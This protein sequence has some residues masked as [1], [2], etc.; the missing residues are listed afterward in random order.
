M[1]RYKKI[2]ENFLIEGELVEVKPFGSGH[3]NETLLVSINNNNLLEKYILRKINNH[4]FKDPEIV[5]L[6]TVYTINHIKNKMQELGESNYTHKKMNLLKTFNF[7]YYYKDLEGFYWCLFDFIDDAYTVDFVDNNEKAYQAAKA[8]GRFQKF[9][10]DAD[11]SKYQESI[12]NFHNLDKRL[13]DLDEALM[14]NPI[15]R[16]KKASEEI[17]IINN[18]RHLSTKI[19]R[20]KENNEIP[21][22]ITHNDTK[23]NNVMFNKETNKAQ[24]VIDL[25]TVMPGTILFDFGDMVRTSTSPV[26]EDERDLSKVTMR[27]EIFESLLKGYLEE[28]IDEL[29]EVEIENLLYGAQVIVYEQA[30]RFLTDYLVGDLYYKVKYELH[31]LIR[32]RNQFALLT[33]IEEQFNEMKEILYKYTCA[34]TSL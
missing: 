22:R 1:N 14:L 23:I 20:M 32:A 30:V 26:E 31:N 33:S 3:I 34:K 24:C 16:V 8:F 21:T 11:I 10:I 13:N 7:Q 6:N 2:V 9:M 29:E 4:V 18:Y 28:L 15:G 19:K 25:D 17:K 5:V 27:L 12:P